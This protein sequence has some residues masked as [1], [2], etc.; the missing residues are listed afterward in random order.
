LKFPK[1]KRIR[2]KG[3]ALRRLYERVL[4]RDGYCCSDCASFVN[5]EVHHIIFKS[6]GGSD[7]D[8]NL[9]TLCRSCHAKRHGI[10]IV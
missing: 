6:A 2:L 1:D 7:T 5:L 9:V 3:D 10:K 4:E 8:L